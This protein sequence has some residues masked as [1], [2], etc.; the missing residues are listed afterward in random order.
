M[1]GM[2]AR[3]KFIM[4]K[5]CSYAC[6][7]RIS[8]DCLSN[9]NKKS[10]TDR[11]IPAKLDGLL[12]R[13]LLRLVDL[14]LS[15]RNLQLDL[16]DLVL[17]AVAPQLVLRLHPCLLLGQ[18][19]ELEQV[20]HL[21]G[22]VVDFLL[23]RLEDPLVVVPSPLLEDFVLVVEVVVGSVEEANLDGKVGSYVLEIL[24]EA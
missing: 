22:Q 20:G 2:S 9:L 19:V 10:V 12:G 13:L 11:S 6:L 16:L 14:Q 18:A 5:A 4:D 3:S 15:Q 7:W 23:G 1:S 8:L 24:K 21:H 17:D